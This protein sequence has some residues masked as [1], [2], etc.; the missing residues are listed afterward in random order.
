[1]QLIFINKDNQELDLL[2]NQDKLVLTAA[3]ALHGVDID[4]AETESPYI[5]GTNIENA[6]V[7]PRGIVLTIKLVGN[8]Q[9]ALDLFTSI[10]KSKQVATLREI[11][12]NGREIEITGRVKIPPYTRLAESV[13][14]QL[15]LYCAQPYWEDVEAIVGAISEII[16]LLC[17]PKPVTGGIEGKAFPVA[18]VPFGVID[19][20]RTKVFNNDGDATIGITINIIALDTVVNPKIACSSGEQNGYYMKLGSATDQFVM[21]SG[22]EVVI[23]TH[24]GKKSI[25]Y[26]GSTVY[27]NRPIMSYFTFAGKDWLQLETGSNEFVIDTDEVDANVYFN[28]L[29]KRRYE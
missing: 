12:N 22:D 11:N 10:V 1:M 17:F 5:D 20:N 29:Y 23:K 9:A 21:N 4:Y 19:T 7:L 26:N 2:N 13:S 6:R 14:V 27:N 15:E 18:G 3:E 8:T 24:R 16:D 28:I 25:T